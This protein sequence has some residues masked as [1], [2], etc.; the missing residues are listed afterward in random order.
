MS[1][2]RQTQRIALAVSK[3]RGHIW[4]LD[5]FSGPDNLVAS[6]WYSFLSRQQMR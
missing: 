1:V 4:M 3:P 2:S 6:I 5:G